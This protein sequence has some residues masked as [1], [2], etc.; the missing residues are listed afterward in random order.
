MPETVNLLEQ[1][2]ENEAGKFMSLIASLEG[3]QLIEFITSV[4]T[5]RATDKGTI[6]DI[7]HI[8]RNVRHID[9]ALSDF[10]VA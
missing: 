5:L 8:S 1:A 10:Y 9:S 4:A 7:I 3:Q 6:E 2:L